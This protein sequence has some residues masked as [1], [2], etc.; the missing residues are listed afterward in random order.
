MLNDRLNENRAIKSNSINAA[1]LMDRLLVKLKNVFANK[2]WI[3]LLGASLMMVVLLSFVFLL[4][5]N[6][7]PAKSYIV[8]DHSRE[9]LLNRLTHIEAR[10]EVLAKKQD[11]GQN[12]T[13]EEMQTISNQLN[14]MQTEMNGLHIKNN[15]PQ[16]IDAVNQSNQTLSK[17][18][19]SLQGQVQSLQSQVH[20]IH[21]LPVT[22]LPFSVIGIDIWNGVPKATVKIAGEAALMEV[23]DSR[24]GWTLVQLNFTAAEALFVNANQ[25]FVKVRLNA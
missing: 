21:Y 8:I 22:A 6:A 19:T 15:A 24:S 3:W 9:E 25:D 5:P 17:A 23:S 2:K 20:P 18:L 14:Q 4:K 10:L 1:Q 13:A 12:P 11:N 7:T 16:I